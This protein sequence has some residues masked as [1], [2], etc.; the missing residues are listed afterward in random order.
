MLRIM[1]IAKDHINYSYRFD[2]YGDIGRNAKSYVEKYGE[3]DL[4][5]KALL[6]HLIDQVSNQLSQGPK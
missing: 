2:F 1:E 3:N 4:D 5:E 6:I